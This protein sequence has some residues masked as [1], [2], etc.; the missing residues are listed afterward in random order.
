[1]HS[2]TCAEHCIHLSFTSIFASL[3]C[4]CQSEHALSQWP[5]QAYSSIE[6]KI[7]GGCYNACQ[8]LLGV[9]TIEV[10]FLVKKPSLFRLRNQPLPL[11]TMVAEQKSRDRSSSTQSQLKFLGC[12][13]YHRRKDNHYRCQ[14]C[15]LNE[16]L[17]L[18]NEDSLCEV[19]KDWLLEAWLAQ[20]KAI[21][22]KRKRKAAAAVKAA[23]KSQ[24]RDAMDDSVEIHAPEDALQLPPSKRKSDGS[25]KTK[26]AK[27]ATRSGSKATEAV[28]AGWPSRSRDQ[29][30]TVSSSVSVVG[31][32]RSN[33]VSGTKGSEGHRSR[34]GERSQRY[35]GSDRRHDSP[36]SHH[37]SRHD[38]M[39]VERVGSGPG[40]RRREGLPP[41]GRLDG[42]SGVEPCLSEGDGCPAF[43]FFHSFSSPS[44]QDIGWS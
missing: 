25:S 7:V 37:S 22:Q 42:C 14:Q 31:Q 19:C 39:D 43:R 24:E 15:R 3:V 9:D 12:T 28:S 10:V 11:L 36:R 34:S 40:P 17:T 2:R 5:S 16:G 8:S 13:H 32:P 20:E 41:G 27:T 18:C 1:M 29:K 35:H 30:K 26:R 4:G 44:S 6:T 21:E 33:G 38:S 23:K